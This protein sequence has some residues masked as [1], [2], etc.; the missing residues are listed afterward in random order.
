M[1][2]QLVILLFYIQVP[3]LAVP[4]KANLI[5]I[6]KF[7]DPIDDPDTGYIIYRILKPIV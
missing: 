5:V 6:L 3:K 2:K 4:N 1:S 7:M